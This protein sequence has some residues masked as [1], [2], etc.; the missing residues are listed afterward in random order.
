MYVL[1]N[2]KNE[3]YFFYHSSIISCISPISS[4]NQITQLY[5][6][7]YKKNILLQN[8]KQIPKIYPYQ[9]V[10]RYSQLH[11]STMCKEYCSPI[12]AF[13]LIG[14][15]QGGIYGHSNLFFSKNMKI[16]N[17]IKLS[18]YFKGP[19]FAST[20]DIIS[21]GIPFTFVS[22]LYELSSREN[23]I[24]YYSCLFGLSI[25][26]TFLSHPL[27]CLQVFCQNNPSY[28]Q[29]K[30]A[31]YMIKKHNLNLF[32]KGISGRIVLLFITN[33]CNDLFLK[34]IW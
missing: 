20:R 15:L 10:L 19:I 22:N 27:H 23:K 14:I 2:L 9:V 5:P 3:K 30:V 13:G 32:Y 28:P 17:N 18:H 11:L 6:Q 12:L 21:Q 29:I 33:L 7:Y 34:E 16:T 1:D 25:T 31:Q 8:L 24:Y 26:S 4:L